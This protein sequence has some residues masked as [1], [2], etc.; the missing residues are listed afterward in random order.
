[1]V[2]LTKSTAIEYAQDGI[3]VNCVNPGYV[4]TP[5]DQGD[6]RGARRGNTGEG[7]DAAHG[8]PNEIAEAV[9]WMCSDK[10]SFMTA[11]RT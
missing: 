1:V 7:A 8:V 5:N 3:R 11:H 6:D 2:G 9:A 4:A 10:A